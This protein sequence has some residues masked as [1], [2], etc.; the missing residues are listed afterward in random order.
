[1]T[2]AGATP[3]IQVNKYL[4]VTLLDGLEEEDVNEEP[5]QTI[6]FMSHSSY[7]ELEMK[8]LLKLEQD[9]NSVVFC[10]CYNNTPC[11]DFNCNIGG[12]CYS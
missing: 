2:L 6:I 9:F 11:C 5:D 10:S 8:T 7:I 12:K 1:M 3:D 4:P